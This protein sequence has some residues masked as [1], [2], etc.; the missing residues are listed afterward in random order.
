[1]RMTVRFIVLAGVVTLALSPAITGAWSPAGPDGLK[2][3]IG[4]KMKT[5]DGVTLV[6]D[7]YRPDAEGRY[8]RISL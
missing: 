3:E 7:V 1:M 8:I 6:A 2:V 5:R 4:V